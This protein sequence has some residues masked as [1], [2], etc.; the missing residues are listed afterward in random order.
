MPRGLVVGQGTTSKSGS[1]PRSDSLK[2]FLPWAEPW[3]VP[4]LQPMRDST[5]ATSCTKSTLG[6]QIHPQHRHGHL[7][8]PARQSQNQLGL[9]V[10][11]G[12]TRPDRDTATIAAE[13]DESTI[14][15][16][17]IR[18]ARGE[19]RGHQKLGVSKPIGQA[20]LLAA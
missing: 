13:S 7:G 15:V 9:A 10:G 16:T 19:L 18:L 3:H 8:R 2:P 17:S 12:R 14:R 20:D 1:Y 6:R 5:G 4:A 11:P